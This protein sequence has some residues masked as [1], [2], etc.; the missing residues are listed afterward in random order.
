MG[1]KFSWRTFLTMSFCIM[2]LLSISAAMLN[3]EMDPGDGTLF[4]TFLGSMILLALLGTLGILVFTVA[5]Y[6]VKKKS[7]HLDNEEVASK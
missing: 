4:G 7:V 5:R 6:G 1:L 2:M 3:E